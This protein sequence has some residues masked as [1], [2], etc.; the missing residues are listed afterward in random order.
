MKAEDARQVLYLIQQ[1]KLMLLLIEPKVRE[2]KKMSALVLQIAEA[3]WQLWREV[4]AESGGLVDL[5]FP[6]TRKYPKPGEP[7]YGPR[8]GGEKKLPFR[9]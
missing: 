4:A 3:E 1:R 7:G 2:N 9:C 6:W 5:E 8:H